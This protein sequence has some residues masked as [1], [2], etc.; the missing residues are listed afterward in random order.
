MCMFAFVSFSVWFGLSGSKAFRENNLASFALKSYASMR[1]V[2]FNPSDRL[3]LDIK[4]HIFKRPVRKVSC[5]VVFLYFH[6]LLCDALL[7][8]NGINLANE[9]DLSTNKLQQIKNKFSLFTC[10]AQNPSNYNG[11]R[12]LHEGKLS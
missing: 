2:L 8:G 4:L 6:G 11:S 5:R 12:R 1:S 3:G 10:Q 9:R 7:A